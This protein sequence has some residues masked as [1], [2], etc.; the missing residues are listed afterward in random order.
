MFWTAATT[1]EKSSQ[2]ISY[3]CAID[4]SVALGAAVAVE[5]LK[6]LCDAGVSDWW[7]GSH[8]TCVNLK[9]LIYHCNKVN[10]TPIFGSL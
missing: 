1:Q 10:L 9:P 5:L 4:A 2:G 3:T 7:K 6:Q 8:K